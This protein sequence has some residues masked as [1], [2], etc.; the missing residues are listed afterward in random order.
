MEEAKK[1]PKAV[2]PTKLEVAQVE[3]EIPENHAW[4]VPIIDGSEVQEGGFMATLSMVKRFYSDPAKF[5][6]KK[7]GKEKKSL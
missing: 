1:Q 7:K 6:I 2:E 5:A 4:V 3:I